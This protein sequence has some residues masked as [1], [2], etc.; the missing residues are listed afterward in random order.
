M[1]DERKISIIIPVYNVEQYMERSIQ[2][3]LQQTYQNLEVILVD[4]GST[5]RSGEICDH[6]K[7]EDTRCIV[8]HK[9]NGGLPDARNAGMDRMTGDLVMF[10]DSDDWLDS[11]CLERCM[12]VM[13]QDSEID[14]VMFPY[15]REFKTQ[16]KTQFILGKEA[17][18]LSGCDVQRRLFGPVGKEKHHP[19]SM[20]DLNSAWG[21]I[22]WTN[23]IHGIR[24]TD[25]KIIGPSEDCMY[26]MELFHFFRKVAYC[27]EIFYHYNKENETSITHSYN[28]VFD[29]QKHNMYQLACAIIEKQNLGEEY[30]AA[31]M[32]RMIFDVMD[33]SRNIMRYKGGTRE[34]YQMMS[35]ML[36]NQELRKAWKTFSFSELSIV[37][38]LFYWFAK[39]QFTS[40]VMTLIIFA[41]HLKRYLR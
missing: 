22:Y 2:S 15:I 25:V 1:N 41:E 30:H 19:D 37:W 9:K 21:K 5:D 31:L 36:S 33:K 16:R 11:G 3:V 23:L 12:D 40:G 34:R 13:R 35:I 20:N 4:D 18:I 7:T 26:N 39:L 8:I 28:P 17:V 10:L 27:P 6:F 24:F 14:C 38:K 32:N 29:Q